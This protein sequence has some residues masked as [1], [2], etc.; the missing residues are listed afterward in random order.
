MRFRLTSPVLLVCLLC[1][2]CNVNH[3]KDV[4]VQPKIAMI[5]EVH[6]TVSQEELEE[7]RRNLLAPLFAT[8]K[9]ENEEKL[10]FDEP[11]HEY[12]WQFDGRLRPLWENAYMHHRRRFGFN[13]DWY[14]T[15]TKG[16]AAFVPQVCA[17]FIVDTIDRTAGTWYAASLKHPKRNIGRF[18]MRSELLA[19]KLSPERVPD[20][21]TYFH[22]NPDKFN[23]IFDN[24][25][26]E[27]PM[28]GNTSALQEWL[29]LKGVRLGDVIFIRGRA[30]WDH[31]KE[32]HY[33]SLFVSG[34]DKDNNVTSVFGNPGY[35]VD[36]TL[37][38]EM[39]RA[40]KR[41]VISI[42]RLTDGFL[43]KLNEQK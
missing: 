35:P 5:P 30:P 13:G 16:S 2:S 11:I 34:V 42:V 3:D 1:A 25:E 38:A 29:N 21:M 14:Y 32:M 22:A 27:G 18:D 31:G 20:L 40:P 12:G 6:I 9:K 33:H 41:H 23:I 19:A 17:D 37:K 4:A 8:M 43:Q 28:T 15:I 10:P 26:G 39:A 24:P 36:H 7:S